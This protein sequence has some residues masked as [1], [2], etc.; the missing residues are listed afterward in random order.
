VTFSRESMCTSCSV[1]MTSRAMQEG[2]S[3]FHLLREFSQALGWADTDISQG[4]R[5]FVVGQEVITELRFSS[6]A[7]AAVEPSRSL[8]SAGRKRRR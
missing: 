4:N 6:L 3:R 1:L 2:S 8:P 7:V 5:R